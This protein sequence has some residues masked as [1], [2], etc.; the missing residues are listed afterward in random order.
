[1]ITMRHLL[2]I[3]V[4]LCFVFALSI[5]ASAMNTDFE[6]EDISESK[7][8]E[9]LTETDIQLLDTAPKMGNII[10]FNVCDD[11]IALCIEER[12]GYNRK[13]LCI[14]NLDGVFLQ[15][16]SFNTRGFGMDFEGDSFLVYFDN[17]DIAVKLSATGQVEEVY[18][19]PYDVNREYWEQNVY[20]QER[21][22]DGKEYRLQNGN[23]F[24]SFLAADYAQL[25]VEDAAGNERI[26]YDNGTLRNAD[27]MLMCAFLLILAATCGITF[28]IAFRR[29]AG[30]TWGGPGKTGDG[31]REP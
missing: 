15:G 6:L 4:L 13:F 12:S 24:V 21:K 17:K 1:M 11:R 14:Y 29:R 8:T 27:L 30:S 2:S 7:A 16:Y 18:S 25:V 20:A 28:T 31:L 9:F 10:S 22:N 19:I 26:L 3:V 23:S 5:S